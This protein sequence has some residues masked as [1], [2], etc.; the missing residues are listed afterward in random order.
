M[1]SVWLATAI[2][3]AS[4]A[5][6]VATPPK[7]PIVQ[8]LIY[9]LPGGVI[10]DRVFALDGNRA[11]FC[12][13]LEVDGKS[14]PN[15][16]DA[17]L[18]AG[19]GKGNLLVLRILDRTIDQGLHKLTIRCQTVY[20][21]PIISMLNSTHLVQGTVEIDVKNRASYVVNGELGST[22]SSVW[23]EDATSGEVRTSRITSNS[24]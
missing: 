22:G 5:G 3:V 1:K 12:V 20:A 9:Q 23:I 6:C 21:M 7:P 24:K 15:S 14:V 16:V 18:E 4:L 17:S 19:R 10:K 2:V 8:N 11:N 13:L